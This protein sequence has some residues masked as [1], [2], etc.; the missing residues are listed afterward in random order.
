M[1]P[2]KFKNQN[3]VIVGSY[4]ND[5]PQYLPLPSH[6]TKEGIVTSCWSLTFWERVRIFFGAKIY[7]S[8]MTFNQPLQPQKPS[9]DW[10]PK[11]EGGSE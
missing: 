5:Q 4:A 9:L 3:A 10:S 11:A 8:Q 2:M 7:W 6:K 1:K